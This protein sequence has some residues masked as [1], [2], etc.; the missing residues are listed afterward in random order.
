MGPETLAGT[1]QGADNGSPKRWLFHHDRV[2]YGYGMGTATTTLS[3]A[4]I[5]EEAAKLGLDRAEIPGISVVSFE[6]GTALVVVRDGADDGAEKLF[7][8][9]AEQ[10]LTQRTR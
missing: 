9:L 10:G 7:A 4:A 1:A 8:H 6:D 2:I 3:G 5:K